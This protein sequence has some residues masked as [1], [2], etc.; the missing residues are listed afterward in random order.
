MTWTVT[1]VYGAVEARP[2]TIVTTCLGASRSSRQGSE[3]LQSIF[4]YLNHLM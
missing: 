4:Y 1:L 3:G 2:L